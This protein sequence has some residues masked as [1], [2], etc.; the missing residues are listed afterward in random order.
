M[1]CGSISTPIRVIIE[2]RITDHSIVHLEASYK[3][4][5]LDAGNV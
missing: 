1:A 4:I 5:A 2:I 3:V